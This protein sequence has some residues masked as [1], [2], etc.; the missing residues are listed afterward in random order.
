MRCTAPSQ[1]NIDFFSSAVAS[2][3]HADAG[4]RRVR[5]ALTRHRRLSR[6]SQPATTNPASAPTIALPPTPSRRRAL[7]DIVFAKQGVR[8]TMAPVVCYTSS[9]LFLL[10]SLTFEIMFNRLFCSNM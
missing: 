3:R 6:C 10:S 1:V 7:E 9:T 2:A 4:H 5:P 8:Q